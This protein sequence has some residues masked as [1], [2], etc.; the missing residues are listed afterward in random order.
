MYLRDAWYI[1]GFGHDFTATPLSRRILGEQ[2]VFYRTTSGIPVALADKCPHRQLPLS[3]GRVIGENIQCG[4]HGAQFGTDGR[5]KLVPGQAEVP[6]A[7]CV[8]SYPVQERHGFVW[9]WM[10]D[11]ERAATV[12]P[13]DL[14]SFLEQ[15]KWNVRDG[16]T[17][18][19]CDYELINDN[20]AD[21]THTEFVHP[22]T[23]GT[24]QARVARGDKNHAPESEHRYQV[25]PVRGGFDIEFF[26]GNTVIAPT[27]VNAYRRVKGED[28]GNHLD[29]LLHFK[30]RAPSF[31]IF[32]TTTTK[33]G[34]PPSEG[35][36]MDGP[37]AMTP[38]DEGNSHYFFKNCQSYAPE[39]DAETGWWFAQTSL[40]FDED[41][42]VL[43][44]QQANTRGQHDRGIS[45]AVSF[46]G[47]AMAFQ[48]RK[49]LR[50]MVAAESG[51]PAAIDAARGEN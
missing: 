31:W 43:E 38:E 10:G 32:S 27:F 5:C 9:I 15:G 34:R 8:K 44:A 1:A 17:H 37:I 29:F 4:Y 3:M 40:A 45:T 13:T 35:V 20:L 26:A 36:R 33:A 41:K 48:V 7:A 19:A 12:E 42:V 11:S 51:Q 18:I 14:Y 22:T 28:P 25:N 39:D 49:L 46:S 6:A 16:Y 21:I 30:F 23:L 2:L 47:D 50:T 24:E